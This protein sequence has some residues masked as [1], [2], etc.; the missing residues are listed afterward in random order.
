MQSYQESI[1]HL[2]F[3]VKLKVIKFKNKCKKN[4]QYPY[5]ILITPENAQFIL[6]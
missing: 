4:Q 5:S 6:L 3:I 2:Q 1:S